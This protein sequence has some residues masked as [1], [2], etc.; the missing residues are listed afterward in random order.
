MTLH[1]ALY[2][3]DIPQNVGAALRLAACLGMT[4]DIIEPTTFPWDDAKIRRSGMDYIDH[5]TIKRHAS[6]DAFA[7]HYQQQ[8]VI[9]LTTKATL[10]YLDFQFQNGDILLAGRASDGVPP[11]VH[12]SVHARIT[13]PMAGTVRS[14]NVVNACAMVCGEALRQVNLRRL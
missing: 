2:Q 9:L 11:H 4:A 6:W 3:P 10:S 8:R 1:L 14:L 12:E 13:I 7:N 5:V